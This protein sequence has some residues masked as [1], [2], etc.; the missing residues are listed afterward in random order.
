[1]GL[2]AQDVVGPGDAAIPTM[3]PTGATD[4]AGL[5]RSGTRVVI[6]GVAF[7]V[8]VN[9]GP[10]GHR[11]VVF[12]I[13]R[14]S[15]LAEGL[16]EGRAGPHFQAD[17]LECALRM[18]GGSAR[19]HQPGLVRHRERGERSGVAAV[20]EHQLATSLTG[21]LPVDAP[22][23]AALMA[24]SSAGEHL[25]AEGDGVGVDRDASA[26]ASSPF[27]PFAVATVGQDTASAG[28]RPRREVDASP[29]AAPLVVR[30]AVQAVGRDPAVDGE[31]VAYREPH[32][33]AAGA[34]GGPPGPGA[35]AAAVLRR[36]GD[37]VVGSAADRSLDATPPGPAMAAT[38]SAAARLHPGAR[39]WVTG[40]G[41]ASAIHRHRTACRDQR[42]VQH[43]D[44]TPGLAVQVGQRR[45]GLDE[46]VTDGQWLDGVHMRHPGKRELEGLR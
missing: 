19:Q 9:R 24:A 43:G 26:P 25:A 21:N 28:D 22:G 38:A 15:G 12:H 42:I 30:R 34:T 7:A 33:A 41:V 13:D 20:V 3:R 45:V 37:R 8:H 46:Q 10:G 6:H 36:L 14:E 11:Q 31:G 23:P 32:H 18:E 1:M 39:P 40:D 27:N 29:R 44:Q 4:R 2:A 5:A 35:T 17:H 16:R